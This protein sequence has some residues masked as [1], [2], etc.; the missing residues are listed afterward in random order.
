MSFIRRRL[1]DLAGLF[2]LLRRL[3][4]GRLRRLKAQVGDLLRLPER[5]KILCRLQEQMSLTQ[6]QMS[7]MLSLQASALQAAV[8]LLEQ[9]QRQLQDEPHQ[10]TQLLRH[11]A[12]VQEQLDALRQ[13]Q[14]GL[15]RSA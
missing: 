4:P 11:L 1:H 8:H 14:S 13:H 15:R 3:T 6:E 2:R 7:L 10:H 12:Q 9:Q 5:G